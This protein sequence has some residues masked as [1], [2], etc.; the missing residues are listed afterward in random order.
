MPKY[1]F[2]R[3]LSTFYYT[4]VEADGYTDAQRIANENFDNF[5]NLDE[6][7]A[8]WGEDTEVMFEED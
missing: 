2:A 1:T 8:E 3:E 7:D 4:T 5:E 6:G